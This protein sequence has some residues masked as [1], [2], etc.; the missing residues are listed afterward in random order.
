MGKIIGILLG[1]R[2]KEEYIGLVIFALIGLVASAL[3]EIVRARKK[4]K[5][6]GGFSLKIWLYDNWARILLSILVILIGVLYGPEIGKSIGIT[7]EVGNKAALV[8]G[9]MT[10]KIIE[11]LVTIK[12]KGVAKKNPN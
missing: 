1:D 3:I 8:T 5:A 7:L 4:I 9:F 10:D 12:R 11:A 2:S 6:R